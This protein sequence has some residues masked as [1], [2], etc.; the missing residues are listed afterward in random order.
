MNMWWVTRAEQPSLSNRDERNSF[1]V[2]FLIL[3]CKSRIFP[4]IYDIFPLW[5]KYNLLKNHL[6]SANENCSI[7]T[8]FFSLFGCPIWLMAEIPSKY[9]ESAWIFLCDLFI[10][11]TFIWRYSFAKK[12]IEKNILLTKIPKNHFFQFWWDWGHILSDD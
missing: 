2:I 9:T 5:E 8:L 11:K 6:E 3:F 10:Y 4:I 7:F 12:V 1:P